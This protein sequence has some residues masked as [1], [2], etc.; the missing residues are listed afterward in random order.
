[1][2]VE[3]PVAAA[4]WSASA[5]C[6]TGELRWCLAT[7]AVVVVVASS[8]TEKATTLMPSSAKVRGPG[9]RRELRVAERA[10]REVA[11]RLPAQLDP[12]GFVG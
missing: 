8:S 9:G 4:I 11:E 6:P 2:S 10:V 1:M 12:C 3:A 7:S 5:L